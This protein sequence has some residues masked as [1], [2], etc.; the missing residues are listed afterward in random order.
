[1]NSG[2]V[3]MNANQTI[4]ATLLTPSFDNI[5]QLRRDVSASTNLPAEQST[6]QFANDIIVGVELPRC[7]RL[8]LRKHNA[9]NIH[10][11]VNRA[12]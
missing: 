12:L 2:I 10:L 6:F 3:K 7:V 11:E 8:F 1:M 5:E 9:Q 4:S